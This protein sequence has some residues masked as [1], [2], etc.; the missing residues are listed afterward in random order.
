MIIRVDTREQAE[1]KFEGIEVVKTKLD[2]ADYSCVLSDGFV[3]PIV[4][5][6]KSIGDL[7]G[8][9]SSGYERFKREVMRCR[10]ARF[11]MF[12]IVEGSLLK[13]SKGT[14]HSSRSG[15]SVLSQ[16]FTIFVKYGVF[17]VFC[18]DASEA[19]KYVEL[20]YTAYEKKYW[21][22]KNSRVDK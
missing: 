11:K 6:R 21:V 1:L 15:D 3:V 22:E 20:F 2:F 10:E 8:T 7:F 12:V 18:K 5:E 4:F 13:V 9:L 19:S 17:P 16:L 14:K